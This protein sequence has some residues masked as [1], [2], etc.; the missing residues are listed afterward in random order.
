MYLFYDHTISRNF[1]RA[2]EVGCVRFWE[3]QKVLKIMEFGSLRECVEKLH[4]EDDRNFKMSGNALE[5]R[6]VA[7]NYDSYKVN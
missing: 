2:L 5:S 3:A 4:Y 6:S 1:L 7:T